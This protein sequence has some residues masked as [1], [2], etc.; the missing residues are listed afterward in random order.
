MLNDSPQTFHSL[1]ASL[2]KY[3]AFALLI[4]TSAL[5]VTGASINDANAAV[6][7]RGCWVAGGDITLTPG[8]TVA[9][10]MNGV[11]ALVTDDS[12]KYI[13]AGTN[14]GFYAST[15]GGGTW[16]AV[17]SFGTGQVYGVAA[18][19]SGKFVYGVKNAS[20]RILI[21][22][23]YGSTFTES[24]TSTVGI[25]TLGKGGYASGVAT[26][27]TGQYVYVSGGEGLQ[28]FF[29]STDFGLHFTRIAKPINFSS[30]ATGGPAGKYVLSGPY[31][32]ASSYYK[33][34]NSGSTWTSTNSTLDNW[35]A[36]AISR[37]GRVQVAANASSHA[38]GLLLST[39][40]GSTFASKGI[41]RN[42]SGVAVA[43]T[44]VAM[45]ADGSVIIAGDESP[46]A[47]G[48]ISTDSGTTF[49]NIA[50]LVGS[51]ASAYMRSSAVSG[52]GSKVYSM[53]ETTK[54]FAVLIKDPVTSRIT[55]NYSM[56]S[57]SGTVASTTS[58]TGQC[59]DGLILAQPASTSALIDGVTS[60]FVGWADSAGKLWYPGTPYSGSLTSNAVALT[61]SWMAAPSFGTGTPT[62]S[63]GSVANQ[64]GGTVVGDV[65]TATY[66]AATG[67]PDS[68]SYQWQHLA[69]G[70]TAW[71]DISDATSSTYTITSTYTGEYI[72]VKVTASN[73][74][75][76]ASESTP[77]S[78]GLGPVLTMPTISSVSITGTGIIGSTDTATVTSATGT[79]TTYQW[80]KS[81]ASGGTYASISGATASTYTLVDGDILQ[82]LKVTA[83]TSNAAGTA[84][85]TSTATSQIPKKANTITFGAFSPSSVTQT[86]AAKT[87][88]ATALSTD[89]VT[90]TTSAAS[91][92]CSINGTTLTITGV[93][94]C[95]VIAA[96]SGNATYAAASTV[97]QTLTITAAAPG[98][99]TITS[100]SSGGGDASDTD[101]TATLAWNDNFPN[102]A[103]ISKYLITAFV[104]GVATGSTTEVTTGSSS[105]SAT[106]TGLTKGTTYTFTVKAFN[107]AGYGLA[108]AASTSVTPAG[109]PFAPTALSVD[110]GNNQ[111]TLNYTPP[112][113]ING[114]TW[115]SYQY[116]ITPAGTPFSLTPTF[117]NTLNAGSTSAGT[118][119]SYVFTGLT[120]GAGYD[121]KIAALTS[122]NGAEESANISV[123]RSI[124]ATVPPAPAI[125]ISQAST[126]SATLT[127]TPTGD[128]GSAIT[129]Y[130]VTASDSTSGA[131]TCTFTFDAAGGSCTLSDISGGDVITASIIATNM[132]GN[133]S[134][135][136][137]TPMTIV[138]LVGIPTSLVATPGNNSLSIAFSEN[139]NG[140]T[141]TGYQWSLDG[142][143]YY[144]ASGI[145][146]PV[147]ISGLVAGESYTI[148]L[149]A[150]GATNGV[151][152]ASASVTGIPVGVTAPAAASGLSATA[153]TNSISLAFAP[154]SNNGGTITNYQYS[155]DG[156]ATFI[157]FSPAQTSSPLTISGLGT[158]TSYSIVVK[159]V[160]SIGA[161]TATSAISVTTT[162]VTP[163]AVVTT[164][165]QTAEEIA[166]A[167]KAAADKVTA[168]KAAARKVLADKAAEDK[169][170]TDKASADKAAAD[171]IIA[172]KASA[173]KAAA[174]KIVSD[175]AAADKVI[176]DKVAADKVIA[177]NALIVAQILKES[178]SAVKTVAGNE[179]SYVATQGGAI[180]NSTLLQTSTGVG[181]SLFD[182][183][184]VGSVTIPSDVVQTLAQKVDISVVEGNVLLKPKNGFT[185]VILVPVIGIVD[186]V[187]TVILNKIAVNPE[188]VE[189]AQSV[190]KIGL[191]TGISWTPSASTAVT[192]EVV[193]N[194]AVICEVKGTSCNVP[195]L[196]GPN[197]KVSIVVLGNDKTISTVTPIEYSAKAPIPAL[198]VSF[199]LNSS[200]LSN[201]QKTELRRVAK[202]IDRE[203]FTRLVVSG[204][205]DAQGSDA[206]NKV[207]SAARAKVTA[208]FLTQLLPEITVKTSAYGAK[209]PVKAGKSATAYAANRRSDISVW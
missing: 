59:G 188:P 18:S 36:V 73:V 203:G 58:A 111:L 67:S 28:F 126:T 184:Y 20:D 96:N 83:T 53:F 40:Y 44:N 113:S 79:T 204:F 201:A 129:S 143:T 66:S 150:I 70:S 19:A 46:G 125:S 80:S 128:G 192:Y 85:V 165:V 162:V 202:I 5:F 17:S 63:A 206:A 170:I 127:W 158:G 199:A 130:T 194:G 90:F 51:T 109:A 144:P 43:V 117:I 166:A 101:G 3:L 200:I 123:L 52:D 74:Y 104:S 157:L 8:G 191:K 14:T 35:D 24:D 86:A 42:V 95:P 21:S 26:D 49:K 4:T 175:K 61:A 30:F 205:T 89:T 159:A 141:V 76:S 149:E 54:K 102:G 62:I 55:A 92:I 163:V 169:I 132:I 25:T 193:R 7:I 33:S 38:P 23:D 2:R 64:I 88:S 182:K 180:T 208:A 178:P 145:A 115:T 177:N 84:S 181:I 87:L 71:A 37:N 133:S 15:N 48:W 152:F 173:D 120:N 118:D 11:N 97:T 29:K 91:T 153:S 174:D 110:V 190:I 94:S 57:A 146:S 39:N 75:G 105:A 137:A 10:A 135:A 103:A 1:H 34:V 41:F 196:I 167:N 68:Y 112:A 65:L 27:S 171:K 161:G 142:D 185:G 60:V 179:N 9:P 6:V 47:G 45:S 124:P 81:S 164:P 138:G 154:G 12:G 93:G 134:T 197:S 16:K 136:S 69:T 139:A 106:V 176:A 131:Q 209:T 151:G 160:N 148:Y 122:A 116:F 155:L 100:I 187:S 119:S 207:L 168:D 147:T 195:T 32:T 183:N 156:G 114:G 82:Y 198:T 22:S 186:G 189:A 107:S 13:Y 99:P 31:N 108:S 77:V 98:A 56:G 78:A 72:G 172:D 50:L 121:I 140:D